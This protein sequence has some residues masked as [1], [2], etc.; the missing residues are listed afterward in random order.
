MNRGPS[1]LQPEGLVEPLDIDIDTLDH[2]LMELLTS[3]W[4]TLD[5]GGPLGKAD[6]L[7]GE[8]TAA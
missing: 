1:R 4:Q 8:Q 2:A 7:L 3:D 5:D 6:D